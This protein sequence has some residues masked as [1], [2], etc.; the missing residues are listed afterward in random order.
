MR[1][2]IIAIF[3]CFRL[4]AASI[5][6]DNWMGDM[7]WAIKDRAINKVIIPGTHNSATGYMSEGNKLAKGQSISH[8]LNIFHC[9]IN[10]TIYNWS[11]TQDLT[12]RKQLNIGV[13]FLDLRVVYNDEEKT[14]YTVH[15]LYCAPLDVVLDDIYDFISLHESEIVLIHISDLRYMNNTHEDLIKKLYD[16]F[17]NN[18]I[19]NFTSPSSTFSQLWHRRKQVIIFYDDNDVN[20]KLGEVAKDFLWSHSASLYFPWHNPKSID[21]LWQQQ[22]E[23]AKKMQVKAKTKEKFWGLGFHISAC[24]SLVFDAINPFAS[25]TSPSSVREIAFNINSMMMKRW[26]SKLNEEPFLSNIR[27]NIITVDFANSYLL[28]RL[29]EANLDN[30]ER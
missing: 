8:C 19:S 28:R 14:H 23:I 1:V 25:S 26:I 29:I 17:K 18:Y 20:N 2:I 12:I 24:K 4:F 21:S 5:T 9:L 10:N 11:K 16:K 7:A 27:P 30:Y 22:I 13:R 6:L 3:C 15:G